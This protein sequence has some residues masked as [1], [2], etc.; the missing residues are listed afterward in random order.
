MRSIIALIVLS[1]VYLALYFKHDHTSLSERLVIASGLL[2]G[3]VELLVYFAKYNSAI[4]VNAGSLKYEPYLV[5][6]TFTLDDDVV[7]FKTGMVLP[8]AVQNE[9]AMIMHDGYMF[10]VSIDNFNLLLT[11]GFLERTETNY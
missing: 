5:V 7:T 3:I 4:E 1:L 8:I 6:E 11:E 10:C 2:V 9:V